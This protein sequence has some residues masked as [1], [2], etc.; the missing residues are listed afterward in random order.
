MLFEDED[1]AVKGKD[2]LENMEV[3]GKQQESLNIQLRR[4][5]SIKLRVLFF[6]LDIGSGVVVVYFSKTIL[7]FMLT[8]HH[9]F[10]DLWRKIISF[11]IVIAYLRHRVQKLL[12]IVL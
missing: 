7:Y 8:H 3:F 2:G 6:G 4:T 12:I 10:V 1:G 9:R 5:D 11:L